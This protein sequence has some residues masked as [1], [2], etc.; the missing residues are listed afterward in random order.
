QTAREEECNFIVLGRSQ[1]PRLA[2]RVVKS[3]VENVIAHAQCHVASVKIG[4]QRGAGR[5]VAAVSNE[6]NAQLALELLPAFAQT[7]NASAKVVEFA[8]GADNASRAETD[9]AVREA[10]PPGAEIKM[11]T[12]GHVADRI[13]Q[14]TAPDDV[15]LMGDTEW[16]GLTRLLVPGVA[17]AVAEKSEQ[18]VVLIRAYRPAR[19]RTLLIRLLT[20]A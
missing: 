4:E 15:I 7:W 12:D 17:D 6:R 1:R 2:S 10:A 13:A 20:G 11:V 16:S 14:E 3:S 8:S 9:R 5:I 18:T 19:K